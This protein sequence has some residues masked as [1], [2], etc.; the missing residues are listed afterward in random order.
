M[1]TASGLIPGGI[2]IVNPREPFKN[3]VF[4]CIILWL[5]WMHSSMAFRVRCL[6]A[7]RS[8]GSQVEVGA[9][10]VG[11][12][13][14]TPQGESGVVSFLPVICFSGRVGFMVRVCLSFSYSF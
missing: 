11:F 1:S 12:K 4:V 7:C 3:C 10:D 14:F 6:G 8:G 2:A 9:L 13:P 5:S